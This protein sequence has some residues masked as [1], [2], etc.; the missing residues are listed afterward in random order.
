MKS[1]FALAFNEIVESRALPHEM[2]LDALRQALVSAYR[3]DARVLDTQ[4]IEAD[5][6][7]NGQPLLIVE[8]EVVD[9]VMNDHTEV[10]LDEA[11]ETEPTAQLGDMVM[12]PVKTLSKSFGRIAAQTAKQVILQHIR[13]AERDTLYNEYIEREGELTIGTVQSVS[14]SAITF[15][16]GRAEALMPSQHRTPTERYRPHEKVR[17]YIAEVKRSNRG[18]Q[19]IV[20]RNHKNMLRRLLEYE[21][22]EIYNGQIEVMSIA[23]EAGFRSKV[24]VAPLQEGIDA[25]GA[26]VGMRGMRIQNIVKE[27]NDEKIDIIEWDPDP[28]RFIA[29]ALSPARVS[30]VFL[31]EDLEGTRTAT[32]IVPSDQ[33]SLAI[34]KEGQNARLAAKLTGWRID[35]KS[36]MEAAQEAMDR[37]DDPPLS[38]LIDTHDE[39]LAEAFRILEKKAENRVVTP[40]EYNTIKEFVS[41]AE[42]MLHE[43]RHENR[44]ERRMMIETVRPLVP[45]AAFEMPLEELELERDIMRVVDRME[46]VGELWVRFM[47]DEEGLQRALQLGGAGQD[48]L[49]AIR[50]ALDSLV[51]PDVYEEAAAEAEAP[52][53]EEATE[54]EMPELALEAIVEA[55]AAPVAEPAEPAELVEDVEDVE[56]E[57]EDDEIDVA[58]AP[59]DEPAADAAERPL[60]A[61]DD[62]YAEFYDTADDNDEMEDLIVRERKK[63]TQKKARTKERK[64]KRRQL[65]YDEDMGEVV[66]RRRRKRDDEEIPDEYEDYF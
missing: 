61:E 15:D 52:V 23:R 22:P 32:V 5:I 59:S 24:A 60:R 35:I 13:E 33:L 58:P 65:I 41:L 46:N 6:D 48:A 40:E 47:A 54:A 50:D 63:S 3:R 42:G 19:I 17:V 43:E 1:D 20:S 66:A 27:L 36:L 62:A 56:D 57:D 37:I 7:E 9:D 39:L 38:Y 34:G 29:R 26:C 4:R 8:K 2:V 11:R 28:A 12:V 31:E 51:I 45:D 55:S 10:A 64:D 44:E 14:H 16:L 49:E 25:V 21:V 53:L 30:N 18:P